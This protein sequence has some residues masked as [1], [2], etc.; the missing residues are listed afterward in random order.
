[1]LDLLPLTA[2]AL[3]IIYRI[4]YREYLAHQARNKRD[5][6]AQARRVGIARVVRPMKGHARQLSC[7]HQINR[8][9]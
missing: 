5:Y 7:R 4:R 2:V 6:G 8:F 9:A 3:G 1:M